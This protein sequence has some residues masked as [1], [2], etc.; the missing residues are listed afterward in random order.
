[1]L[2]KPCEVEVHKKATCNIT[3]ISDV[4]KLLNIQQEMVIPDSLILGVSE[5]KWVDSNNVL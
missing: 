3:T 4:A 5:M 2:R 1:M